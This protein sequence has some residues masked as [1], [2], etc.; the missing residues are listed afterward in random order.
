MYKNL[1]ILFKQQVENW[2]GLENLDLAKIVST[3]N[4]YHWNKTT[5]SN[6]KILIK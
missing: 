4:K 1:W 6:K 2:S 5:W 3:E